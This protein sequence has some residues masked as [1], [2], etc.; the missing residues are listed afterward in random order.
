M[1]RRA[2]FNVFIAVLVL[3]FSAPQAWAAE[4]SIA[5]VDVQSLL[6]E[7]DAAKS[8]QKQVQVERDKFVKQL[9]DKED[10]LR[11]M[12]KELLE[13]AKDMEVSELSKKKKEFEEAFA[14]TRVMAQKGK[15]RIDGALVE[16]MDKLK[17]AVFEA[18]GEVAE[19]KG[20]TLILARQQV[21]ASD[22]SLDISEESMQKLN[23]AVSDITLTFDK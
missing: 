17:K 15:A 4:I 10:S 22:K 18:V 8:I 12:E 19:E 7:S 14:E 13:K 20:F 1:N 11:A 21:V 9:K 2:L 23:A 5:V 6:T 16:G 3:L